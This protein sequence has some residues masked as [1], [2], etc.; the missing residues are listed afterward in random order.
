[1]VVCLLSGEA[2][3]GLTI[4]QLRDQVLGLVGD[5][6]PDGVRET[7]LTFKDVVNDL[8]VLLA[9][10]GRLAG[11]HDEQDNAHGP[12]VTLGGVTALE[13]LRCDVVGCTI[14]RIHHLVLTDALGETEIDQ[15]D[16]RVIILFVQEEVLR[17]NIPVAN[18]VR[19]KIVQGV[20]GLSHDARGLHLRQMLLLRDVEEKFATFAKLGDEEADTLGLPRLVQLDDVRMVHAHKDID[21]V[22]ERLVVLNFTL[23]HGFDGHLFTCLL[24]HGKIDGTVATRAKLLLKK[25]LVLD[26]SRA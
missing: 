6:F 25:V 3:I 14:G 15:L 11:Q 8:F 24:I 19:M 10:K 16:V 5:I 20:E 7:E 2:L 21:L 22:L 26:I 17:L 13:H 18:A 9:T 12:V 4:Q 23:L 1:M